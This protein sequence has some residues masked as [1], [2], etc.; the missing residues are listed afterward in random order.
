MIIWIESQDAAVIAL[1]AFL[2][3]Y[4]LAAL[5]F[6]AVLWLSRR[7]VAA[8]L[9]ATTPVM[10]TPLG[11][12][13]G[14]VIGFLASHVW[15]NVDRANGY[16]SQEADA[17]RETMLLAEAL[18]AELRGTVRDAIGK[19]LRFVDDEDWPAM[20]QGRARAGTTP[21]GL[22][23]A[24]T[25]LLSYAPA[26]PGQQIAQQRAVATIERALEARWNRIT[27]SKAAISPIQWAT[28]VLLDLLL[29]LTIG[30]VHMDR[31]PA[32]ALNLA[33]F[34]TAIAACLILLLV[35]DRPFSTGGFILQP[36]ALREIGRTG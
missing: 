14:L 18:P 5:A 19:Y 36:D 29:L 23:E 16:V 22:G 31:W 33:S 4:A 20:M 13:A 25:A 1:L 11:L 26:Q 24:L 6:A 15:S 2:L 8:A 9:K 3:S 10:L 32:A 17:L 27:L 21:V 35:N 12:L 30:I 34:A 28:I 7:P